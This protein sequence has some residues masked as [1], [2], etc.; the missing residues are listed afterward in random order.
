MS[1]YIYEYILLE[2]CV[3]VFFITCCQAEWSSASRVSTVSKPPRL[4][5]L[6]DMGQTRVRL[7]NR[8][9]CDQDKTIFGVLCDL[10]KNLFR[11]LCEAGHNSF[12][13]FV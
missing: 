2:D 3:P 5:L 8:F 9:V 6:C 1:I 11:F 7:P 12:S 10:G 13:V 4:C